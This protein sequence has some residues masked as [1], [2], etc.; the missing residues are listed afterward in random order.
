[1]KPFNVW[2]SGWCAALCLAGLLNGNFVG[3]VICAA[4]AIVNFVLAAK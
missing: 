4:I 2:V 1:M 3:A